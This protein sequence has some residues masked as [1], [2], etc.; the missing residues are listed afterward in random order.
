MTEWSVTVLTSYGHVA[1]SETLVSDSEWSV[2]VLTSYGHVAFSETL[3][4]D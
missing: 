3:V 1:F 2:T 4:T